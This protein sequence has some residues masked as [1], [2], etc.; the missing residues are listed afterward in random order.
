MIEKLEFLKLLDSFQNAEYNIADKLIDVSFPSDLKDIDNDYFLALYSGI[1]AFLEKNASDHREF[2]RAVKLTDIKLA[3]YANCLA[4]YPKQILEDGLKHHQTCWGGICKKTTELGYLSDKSELDFDQQ[5]R[6]LFEKF[7]L[8]FEPDSEYSRN[9][10]VANKWVKIMGRE[11]NKNN[12]TRLS[13]I[14][15]FLK[16]VFLTDQDRVIKLIKLIS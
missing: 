13:R 2:F 16:M 1:I 5:L 11:H 14:K 4:E 9:L 15:S 7:S 6:V 8:E 10:I 3:Y 12:Y